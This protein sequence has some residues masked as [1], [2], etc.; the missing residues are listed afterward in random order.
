[1]AGLDQQQIADEVGVARTTV[2]G[3]ER[4]QFEPTFS[5]IVKWSRAT[6]QPLDWFAEGLDSDDARSKGLEPPT[7]CSVADI[8]TSWDDAAL[9][10][11]VES[12]VV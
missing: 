10:D 8:W 1:L 4:G 9:R 11:Y 3:W 5:I 7:F 12:T 2:S 6:N